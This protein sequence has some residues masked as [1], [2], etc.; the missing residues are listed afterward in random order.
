[1]NIYLIGFM[2][3]G[4]SSAGKGIAACLRWSFTDLDKLVEE[5]VGMTV[6]GI[7]AS[8][9]EEFFRKAEAEAL[10]DVSGQTRRVVACG[11][12]TPCSDKNISLMK[13]TGVT[14]YLRVTVDELV[15]R[16]NRSVTERPLLKD[17]GPD[18]LH[19]SVKKL[20]DK[21]SSWYEQADLILDPETMGEEEMTTM[22]ADT[23]RSKGVCL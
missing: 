14:V 23:V 10:Q 22:I 12:G 5:K 6:A 18:E 20:L 21:R 9:G 2:G 19:S 13:A 11:G 17:A 3:S 4:K 16:L 7:F 8:K 1:M 15:S